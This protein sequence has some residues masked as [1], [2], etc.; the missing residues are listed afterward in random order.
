MNVQMRIWPYRKKVRAHSSSAVI[1]DAAK[2]IL[3]GRSEPL[4][5]ADLFAEIRLRISN[6][7]YSHVAVAMHTS[8]EF[9]SRGKNVGW[10]LKPVANEVSPPPMA[11]LPAP[12]EHVEAHGPEPGWRSPAAIAAARG[13]ALSDF[14]FGTRVRVNETFPYVGRGR[15]GT[16]MRLP[17]HDRS[18]LQRAQSE[19]LTVRFDD[20]PKG[21]PV[22]WHFT[23]FDRIE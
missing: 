13:V 17:H 8:E 9:V 4:L 20:N 1:R 10:S 11:Q 15:V 21:R 16:V 12:P 3:S 19:A 6:V 5:F 14:Q 23:Y 18:G 7:S 2:E 22:R